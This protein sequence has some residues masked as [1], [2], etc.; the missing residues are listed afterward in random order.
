MQRGIE[1]R[2]YR[3]GTLTPREDAVYQFVTR[4]ARA[5]VEGSIDPARRLVPA[6]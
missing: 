1:S 4:I 2:G 6:G 3:P 5:Y